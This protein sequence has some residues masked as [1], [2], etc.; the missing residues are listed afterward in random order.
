VPDGWEF[1][2]QTKTKASSSSTERPSPKFS[3]RSRDG[4]VFNSLQAIFQKPPKFQ[5]LTEC[6]STQYAV[7]KRKNTAYRCNCDA[8]AALFCDSEECLNYA[9]KVEC[10]KSC[11]L[12]GM[13]LNQRLRRRVL[14]ENRIEYMGKKGWGFVNLEDVVPG[15]LI[16]EYCGE[17]IN[18]NEK[19][20]RLESDY[21]D[22]E[23]FYLLDIEKD[24]TIDATKKGGV[25]RFIN[26][27][28]DPNAKAEKWTVDGVERIGIFA[29]KHIPSGSEV[30][31]D[32]DFKRVGLKEQKCYCGS[33]NCR[34]ILGRRKEQKLSRDESS[35]SSSSSNNPVNLQDDLDGQSENVEM[36]DRA[37]AQETFLA[38]TSAVFT[39]QP[40]RTEGQPPVFLHRNVALTRRYLIADLLLRARKHKVEMQTK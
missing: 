23:N 26:H 18:D 27:S 4:H 30:T 5:R 39:H 35:S 12:G 36:L 2:L 22:N 24:L 19:Q 21:I 20:R 31:F 16:G 8:S 37:A 1:K 15:Q 11:P 17:L 29:I 38:K 34:G 33:A 13:C 25:T 7:A 32:Y 40:G 3:F 10:D 9:I 14:I 6:R 28:C